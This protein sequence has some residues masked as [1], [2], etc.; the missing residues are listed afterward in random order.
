MCSLSSV[1]AL[2]LT[3]QFSTYLCFLKGLN[4]LHCQQ[5][6]NTS[7]K[8][9]E[10]EAAEQEIHPLLLQ[11]FL[12]WQSERTPSNYNDDIFISQLELHTA[13]QT[14]AGMKANRSVDYPQAQQSFRG[15]Y[16]KAGRISVTSTLR[17]SGTR[18]PSP[19]RLEPQ[20]VHPHQLLS[21]EHEHTTRSLTRGLCLV[22]LKF[23]TF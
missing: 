15:F 21:L 4:T 8:P 2:N 23:L 18:R 9:P 7:E 20:S 3:Y 11:I 5:L 10:C 6:T 19:P 22:S 17:C 1:E 14:K 13:L 12:L 16:L